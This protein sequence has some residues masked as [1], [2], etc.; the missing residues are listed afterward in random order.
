MERTTTGSS[1]G[2]PLVM[3]SRGVISAGH[4][5]A[6]E[7]GQA[8]FRRGGNAVDAAAAAGFALTVLLPN[9]NGLLGEAPTLVHS[10]RQ[11]KV[12]AVSG[13]GTAPRAAS[14]EAMRRLGLEIMPGDG[15]LPAVVPSAV[16]TWI[17]LLRRFGRLR[18]AEVLGPA[19]E[20]AD[21]GFPV[22]EGLHRQIAANADRF[23]KDWPSSAE[24][25]LP[26]GRPPGIGELWR[27]PDLAR[28][29]RALGR[30]DA[31]RRG[32][33][34]GLRAAHEEFYRGSIARR[35]VAFCKSSA[36][37]DSTGSSHTGLLSLEDFAAYTAR[38][39][40]PASAV[41]R[42]LRVYKCPPWTQ[43]PAMLQTL[44]LLEGFDLPAMGL[45]SADY[46]HTVVECMKLAYADR[47][48]Y[49]GDPDFARV[50][51]RRLLSGAY[52]QRRRAL[53]DPAAASM[54]LRP[55][56][57]PA[58]AAE[59]ILDVERAAGSAAAAGAGDTTSV[60]AADAEGNIISA[61]CSGGWLASSPVV[62]GLGC[63]LGTRGQ[64]FCLTPGHP[65]A[66]E[67]GK[68]PR[69]TLT[70]SL[71]ARSRRP[72]HLAFGCPGG[73]CQDQW[74]L[75]FLLNLVEFG[76][77]LQE[78]VEAPTFWTAHWPESFYPRTAQPGSLYLESR[79]AAPVRDELASRGH[80]VQVRPAWAGGNTMAVA[81]D[82]AGGALHAAASPRYEPAYAIGW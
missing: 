35:I 39:E 22:F 7:A 32:R 12:W 6:A 36:V 53:I 65:N 57:M 4:Y 40:E 63:P 34:A 19:I 73:D 52:A 38:L 58:I 75:Q 49:Y 68:R 61:V 42:G 15:L 44:K 9:Q 66:L 11:G 14:I 23:R 47:E 30:A 21:G 2:R 60:Q 46:V 78:A 26:G 80:R 62:P 50:P 71:A 51:L 27:Q 82:Q 43:G 20:L 8:M 48:F 5:L 33:A 45:N 3:G 13:H 41:Y 10:A 67:P 77:S 59:S 79:L 28:T 25:Y 37:P 16:A 69:T 76:M 72:P 31:R 64:M 74:G 24:A 1:G 56:D 29:L 54:E 17:E 18:L 70:P 55:G 81:R